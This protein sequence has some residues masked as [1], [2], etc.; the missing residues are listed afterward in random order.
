MRSR[1]AVGAFVSL[2]V[3]TLLGP[4]PPV[5]ADLQHPCGDVQLV[6]ARG[7]GDQLNEPAGFASVVEA[8][9]D[10]RLSTSGLSLIYLRARHAT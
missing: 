3:W 10:G 4:V 6:I 9:L 1:R 8:E 7:T 5:A 2:F